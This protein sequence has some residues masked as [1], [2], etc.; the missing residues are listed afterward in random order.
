[1]EFYISPETKQQ[2]EH[3]INLMF[4]HLEEKPKVTFGTV[5]K[6]I[7]ETIYDY[8]YSGHSRQRT[9][10][11][12]IKVE[13]EDIRTSYWVLVATVDYQ[14][15]KLLMGDARYFKDIPEQYGLSYTK[16]DHCG[17]EHKHRNESHIL[18]NE[19]TDEWMQVGSTCIN[20]MINGGKYLNGLM[21][22]LYDVITMY[23]GCDGDGWY[24]GW[25]KPSKSYL[26]EGIQIEEAIAYCLNYMKENGDTWQKS[27]WNGSIKTPGTNDFLIDKMRKGDPVEIDEDFFNKV[28]RYFDDMERGEDDEYNGPSLT[29]KIIDAFT[30]DFITLKEMYIPWFAITM[31]NNTFKKADFEDLVKKHGIEKGMEINIHGTL[32]ALNAIETIDWRGEEGYVYEAIFK[33]DATGIKFTKEI[34]YPSVIDR[35]KQEDGT[36]KFAGTIKY[37][38]YKRQYVG[39]GGRLKKSK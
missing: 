29:Q 17:A 22:K 33:D 7:K 19:D 8:G 3:K 5:E 1:M 23:G 12:A 16:C 32:E 35:F 26:Y 27:E 28:R 38:A 30:N 4:K 15:N 21:M 36:Y 11:E 25:W 9:K 14:H 10:V 34:S 39:L 37:I 6:I 18:Y 2:V 13:I 20:K 24:H 31:Y